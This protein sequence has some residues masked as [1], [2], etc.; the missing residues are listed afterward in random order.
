[1]YVLTVTRVTGL[2]VRRR[3]GEGSFSLGEGRQ[4][5]SWRKG[6]SSSSRCGCARGTFFASGLVRFGE[7]EAR[8]QMVELDGHFCKLIGGL[9]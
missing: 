7:P 1:M 5:P 2:R 8:H 9:L 6:H 4:F 3:V